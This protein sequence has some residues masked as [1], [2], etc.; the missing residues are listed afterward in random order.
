MNVRFAPAL[1]VALLPLAVGLSSAGVATTAVPR[2]HTADLRVYLGRGGGAAGSIEKEVAFRNRSSHPC[3]VYGYAGFGLEDARHHV[4]QSRVTWGSTF[5]QRDP[6]RHRVVLPPGRAAFANLAWNDV[7][8]GGER[9]G[10]SAWL[11]VTPPDERQYRLVRFGGIVCNHGHV[12][13]TAI[14][15]IRPDH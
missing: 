1:A 15:R 11:E 7:P 3:F 2:C 4:K 10:A 8:V 6:G 5:A 14:S 13:A 9:C 12:T